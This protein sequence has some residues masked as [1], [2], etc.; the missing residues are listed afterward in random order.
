MADI[1]TVK[2]ANVTVQPTKTVARRARP[3]RVSTL[4]GGGGNVVVPPAP[5]VTTFSWS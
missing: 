3:T 5:P 1:G 4:G 2:T